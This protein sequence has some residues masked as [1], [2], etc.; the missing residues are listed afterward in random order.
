MAALKIG[1]LALLALGGAVWGSGARVLAASA[2]PSPAGSWPSW[3]LFGL[4]PILFTLG[5]A[6]HATYIA[7]S[8]RD[9]ERSVPRGIAAG[10]ALVLVAYLGVNVAYLAL[11][12]HDGLAQSTSPAAD[13]VAV[14]LGPGAGR[15][16]AAAIVVSAAGILNTICLGF[17][18][19]LYAMAKDGVFFARAGRLDARTGRPSVAVAAQG[20]FA[21]AAVIAGS[22]RIDVLLTGIAFAD[23]IFSAAVAI[24][25]LR[26]PGRRS[27]A[28]WA[29]LFLLFDL[30]IAIGCLVRAPRESAYGVA[31]LI[32]GAATWLLWR[33]R[34]RT[35]PG[36]S[37]GP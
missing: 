1:A 5:G 13:A 15:V 19:V 20:G 17:P 6:Y 37:L 3:L 33:P 31:A 9:P 36:G 26:A 18:F 28:A 10:I 12:G 11:L 24:V 14:A 4:I 32:A 8:V 22:S 25:A 35:P 7:G 27:L 34:M 23:A 30:G 29:W 2:L 21:C 16:I